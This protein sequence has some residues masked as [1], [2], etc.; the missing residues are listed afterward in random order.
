HRKPSTPASRDANKIAIFEAFIVCG[1][2]EKARLAMNIDIVKQIPPRI[3]ASTTCDHFKSDGNWHIPLATATK[4]RNVTPRGFPAIKPAAMPA[5]FALV[6]WCIQS[7]PTT[8]PVFASA[9]IGKMMNAT[10]LCKKCSSLCEG[11]SRSPSLAE[12]G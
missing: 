3:T 7:A 12:N 9:K 8:M 6:K 11:A 10:G 1:S 2:A 4:Q 5:L